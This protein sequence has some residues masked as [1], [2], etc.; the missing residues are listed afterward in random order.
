MQRYT[1]FVM[2]QNG[3]PETKIAS[4]IGVRKSTISRELQRNKDEN[5]DIYDWSRTQE[6]SDERQQDRF[7]GKTTRI[8]APCTRTSGA[9][10]AERRNEG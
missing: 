9:K 2:R 1:I 3:I 10:G 6:K 7:S 8:A 5:S 4:A